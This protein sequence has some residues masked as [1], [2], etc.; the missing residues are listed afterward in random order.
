MFPPAEL[1]ET[2]ESDIPPAPPR[3]PHLKW[4][5]A[6]YDTESL[7]DSLFSSVG[8]SREFGIPS[9]AE[10]DRCLSE[11]HFVK[12]LDSRAMGRAR[13]ADQAE[14]QAQHD[15]DEA[16]TREYLRALGSPP[17]EVAVASTSRGWATTRDSPRMQGESFKAYRQRLARDAARR[18][19][20]SAQ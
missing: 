15:R 4:K 11:D 1:V 19:S 9:P 20:I 18:A 3:R 14:R 10:S 16:A 6:Q 13:R 8:T 17:K 2:E 5:K 7:R 12:K